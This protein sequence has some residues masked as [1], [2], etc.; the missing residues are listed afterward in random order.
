MSCHRAMPCT[1]ALTNPDHR[2][3]LAGRPVYRYKDRSSGSGKDSNGTG[4]IY[5]A[6]VA[7]VY[8][9]TGS[10]G[11]I[12][13]EH[14]WLEPRPTWSQGLRGG[15]YEF[16]FATIEAGPSSLELKYIRSADGQ[17]IDSFTLVKG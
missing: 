9:N 12:E 7:P 16:G 11:N 2:T 6:G 14:G 17:V 15:P 3:R 5:M 13:V 1:R 4:Q 10:A 8:V